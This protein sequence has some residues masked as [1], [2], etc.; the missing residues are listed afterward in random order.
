VA[1]NFCTAQFE[2]THRLKLFWLL[3]HLVRVSHTYWFHYVSI[4][5][6]IYILPLGCLFGNKKFSFSVI[7]IYCGKSKTILNLDTTKSKDKSYYLIALPFRPVFMFCY[8]CVFIYT[9][10]YLTHNEC[11][12]KILWLNLLYI[13]VYAIWHCSLKIIKLKCD[14][15]YF[16][17]D[18]CNKSHDVHNDLKLYKCTI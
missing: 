6:I 8:L 10:I 12:V 15:C 17:V 11:H 2:Y 7:K 16:G 1:N 18:F 14:F 5:F 9:C 3:M 13:F 4:D